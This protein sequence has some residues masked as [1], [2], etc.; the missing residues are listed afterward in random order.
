V[1][2][3]INGL[4]FRE[5]TTPTGFA[6]SA[7]FQERLSCGIYI[8]LFADGEEYVG[9]T[10]HFPTRF[11]T[12][13]RRW[14]DIRA[15]RFAAVLFED[16]YEAERAVIRHR[17]SAGVRLRNLTLLSQPLGSSPFDLIVDREVQAAWLEVEAT[18]EGP[19]D[20]D[21][22]RV[23][24]AQRRIRT[25]TRLDELRAHT[26]FQD[27]L[28][29]VAGYIA[30]VIP[31]PHQTE[32][33]QWTLTALPSTALARDN[34]RLATLS[35]HNVE[36]L[37]LGESRD[38][39]GQWHP[40]TFM[41]TGLMSRVPSEIAHLVSKVDGYRSAGR[42]HRIEVAGCDAVLDLLSIP[43]V[44]LAARSLALG[45]L[46]KGQSVFSRFHNDA[47]ADEVFAKLSGWTVQPA[48]SHTG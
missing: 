38:A 33:M 7:L 34:R 9:Q 31:W 27:V 2:V 22:Q 3:N 39:D 10:V 23:L 47:F 25:R 40:Y 4:R 8:L 46:R 45:Q 43:R 21:E 12:H 16:L 24:I 42:V 37:V 14:T 48:S 30:F 41:N 36:V 13:R 6:S 29:S 17:T 20:L 26:R 18:N 32:G 11:S 44:R 15:V 1:R 35:I 19:V 5:W 28:E